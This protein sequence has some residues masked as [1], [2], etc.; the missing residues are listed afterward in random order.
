MKKN[1][2]KRIFIPEFIKRN[3]HCMNYNT[4]NCE[5]ENCQFKEYHT[6]V[7]KLKKTKTR[8]VFYNKRSKNVN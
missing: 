5:K 1:E 3:G 2:I 7:K 8:F 4:P 6:L